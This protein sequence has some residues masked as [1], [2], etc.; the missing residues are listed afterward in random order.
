MW[1]GSPES[2]KFNWRREDG[3]GEP[4]YE[5][6][7]ITYQL[8]M[9]RLIDRQL[10]FSYVKSFFGCLL[11]ILSLFIIV[12]LFT[13]LQNFEDR[14]KGTENLFAFIGN[15][16]VAMI[17]VIYNQLSEAIVLLAAMFTVAWMQRN[18]ELLPLL[19]A[20]VSTRRVVRP[21]LIAACAMVALA[22]V[23][24]E[25]ILPRID[26]LL[27]EERTD[28]TL[29]KEIAVRG[30][31]ESNGI[32]ISGK[33]ATRHDM[34]IKE[35]GCVFPNTMEF[36]ALPFIQ[37]KEAAYCPPGTFRE[38][39]GWFLRGTTP[40]ELPPAGPKSP[41]EMLRPGVFFLKTIEIDFHTITRSKNFAIY[42]PTWKL[43]EE[44]AR[45]DHNKRAG[46]AVLFHSRFVRPILGMLLVFMGLSI[47]LRDQNRNIFISA[48]LCLGLCVFFFLVGGAC[49]FLGEHDHLRPDIAAL[50]P[51]L[52]FGP[53]SFV[54]FDAVHT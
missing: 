20:G 41:I 6:S 11:S 47:I 31:Y 2:S 12:D 10:T 44:L 15:Y 26:G 50:L 16:Y 19:S 35:F 4:S 27:I 5:L 23:N 46:L 25:L 33:T 53:I 8:L 1:D 22:I 3:S 48:G 49:K 38:S 52:I 32:H 40:L 17:P 45:T 37:A 24:Q 51:V 7:T 54:M 42:I 43:F 39:G 28:A 14:N 29:A 36:D 30:G 21:V 34:K 13:N 9:L 18:N